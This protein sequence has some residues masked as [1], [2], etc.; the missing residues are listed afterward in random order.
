MLMTGLDEAV[1]AGILVPVDD[2]GDPAYQFR[3]ALL[4]E[5]AYD[6]LLPAERVRLHARLVDHLEAAVTSPSTPDP[7]VVAEYAVHAYQAH[8]QP[9]ALVGSVRAV[10]ALSSIAAYREAFGH[11]ERAIELWPRVDH[12]VERAGIRMP[13]CWRSRQ[14]IAS[15]TNQ[16]E[17]ATS[18]LHAALV[19]SD[20]RADPDRRAELLATLYEIAWEAEDF[21]ASA[22]AIE[23]ART[24]RRG[25][26]GEP[27]EGVRPP[28]P[29]PA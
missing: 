20:T 28:V 26:G 24:P 11:A 25:P 7:W 1:E 21:E 10:Q 19:E 23:E 15:A 4:R 6:D 14:R 16:R 12:A 22:A 29:G 27:V 18:L 8:D 2:G 9:R 5:A 3:H 17:R 13:S